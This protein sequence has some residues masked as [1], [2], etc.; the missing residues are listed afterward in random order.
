MTLEIFSHRAIL[1]AN[2][3][4][5]EGISNCLK[6]NFSLELDLRYNQDVYLSH[7]KKFSNILFEDACK[8]LQNSN[9]YI[10]LHMKE[11]SAIHDT[12]EIIK[13]YSLENN[14]F[15]FMTDIDYNIIKNIV[16][17]NFQI[18]YYTSIA[19][20]IT[21]STFYWCDEIKSKWYDKKIIEN[22]HANN[23]LCIAM[24]P[25]LIN[26]VNKQEI[27]SE[28]ERLI[29]LDFDGICTDFPLELKHFE[30]NISI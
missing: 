4:S 2:E 24:S 23:I 28:W 1:D 8:I 6:Y 17:N 7:D 20:P 12:I 19:P 18:A 26:Q 10:A 9:S 3:N 14:S 11:V 25:E 13:D 22:L 15:L 5:L 21:D 29:N 27:Y 16:N 30:E